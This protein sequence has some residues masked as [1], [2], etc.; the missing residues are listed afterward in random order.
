MTRAS[1][2]ETME[3]LFSSLALVFLPALLFAQR[4]QSPA[5]K[6]LVLT[7]VTVID[8]TGPPPKPDMTVV[9]AGG[10]IVAIDTSAKLIPP[11]MRK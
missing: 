10:R 2:G 1:H 9:I 3:K 11:V 5:Q 4:K 8:T 7:H 6:P